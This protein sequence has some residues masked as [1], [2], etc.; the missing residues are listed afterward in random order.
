M[1][2]AREL[3]LPMFVQAEGV[4][5]SARVKR[6][7]IDRALGRRAALLCGVCLTA[8]TVVG[9]DAARAQEGPLIY[10]PN[11]NGNDVT[12]IATPTNTILPAT[13]PVGTIPV[14][15]A[16][17]GDQSLVYVSNGGDNTVSVI[18]T[19]TNT[20]VATVPVGTL[21]SHS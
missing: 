10:V 2:S 11:L 7:F 6:H 4:S 15:A 21:P 9:A 18:D 1:D 16:V 12:V 19:S 14:A 20:V 3:Q 5:R 13:I 17:R 8:M